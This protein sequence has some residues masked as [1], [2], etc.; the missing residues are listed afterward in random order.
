MPNFT[1]KT[2]YSFNQK[3]LSAMGRLLVL[4]RAGHPALVWFLGWLLIA[5]SLYFA[6]SREYLFCIKRPDHE[7]PII[8]FGFCKILHFVHSFKFDHFNIIIGIFVIRFFW[9]YW[10]C[11]LRNLFALERIVLRLFKC[12]MC[13]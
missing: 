13:M 10:Y 5:S 7:Y 6:M 8:F 2:D 3:S 9:G 1:F 12:C 4:E 11:W